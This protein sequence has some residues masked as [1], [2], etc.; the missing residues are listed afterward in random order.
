MICLQVLKVRVQKGANTEDSSFLMFLFG[1]LMTDIFTLIQRMV[2][3]LAAY[4]SLLTYKNISR[5]LYFGHAIFQV[6][7]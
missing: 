1:E 7:F 3:V 2:K 4:A 6:L 5:N